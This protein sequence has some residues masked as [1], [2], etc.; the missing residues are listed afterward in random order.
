MINICVPVLRRYDLLR[1]LFVSLHHSTVPIDQIYVVDNGRDDVRMQAAMLD[2]PV[3]VTVHRPA[4]PLGLAVAWNWFLNNV[5]EERII[6]NDDIR[7]AFNSVEKI[8]QTPGDLVWAGFGFSCFLL[9]DSC[10]AKLGLF[11]ETIS[12]GYA[13]YEDEDYLQRLDGRGTRLPSAEAR[14]VDAGLQ[15]F[16][17]GTLRA[18]SHAEVLEHHRRFLVAQGNYARKWGVTF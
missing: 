18:A 11:D 14:N 1:E 6:T 9:R 2:A 17:S 15:H 10:V 3:G 8:V 12:P 4:E 16:H 13:Y 7:F 5:P